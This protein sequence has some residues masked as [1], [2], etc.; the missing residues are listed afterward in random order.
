MGWLTGALSWLLD[1]A[2][3]SGSG[4]VWARLV[5]H[6][7]LTAAS[8]G[9]ACSVALPVALWLGHVGRGGALAI[10]VSNVG[11][12]VPTFALL[13]LFSLGPPPLGRSTFSIVLALT[14]FAIPPIITNTYV[15]IRGVDRE[16]VEAATGM[17]MSGLQVLRRVELPLAV[18]LLMNGVR[19]AAV[20]IV[21]TATIAA[22][23]AG[24]GLG[25]IITSGFTRQNQDQV[26]A[27]ALLV[28]LLAL[29]VELAFEY[30]QRRL[31][32][33]RADRAGSVTPRP[34]GARESAEPGEAVA[35]AQP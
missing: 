29:V 34:P 15:G 9:L 26:V 35:A 3:W 10:N 32:P 2:N 11:R 25:R 20:Q 33:V 28:G 22:L 23:V 27:G 31:D 13:A 19:I 24:G 18:P 16:V 7:G 14:L 21:A 17:G 5:E 8:L 12:A 4:G 1:P 30:L 6:L